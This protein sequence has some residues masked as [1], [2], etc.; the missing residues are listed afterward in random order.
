MLVK[1]LLLCQPVTLIKQ[2]WQNLLKIGELAEQTH[3]AVAT[4]RYYETLG[5]LEPVKKAD[6]GYRYYDEKAIKR[7]RFIKQAQALRFS[8]AE[9]QQVLNVRHQGQP[10]CPLVKDLLDRKIAELEQSIQQAI[11]LKAELETY[12]KS[13]LTRPLDHLSEDKICSLIEEVDFASIPLKI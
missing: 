9:I 10:T 8:L 11:L 4:I 13:W 7:L 5:L 2:P 12:R 3:V 1:S 6:N